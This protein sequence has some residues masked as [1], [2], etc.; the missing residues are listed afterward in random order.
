MKRQKTRQLASVWEEPGATRLDSQ[1]GS[2]DS[3]APAR[4]E[5]LATELMERVVAGAN[6]R[7]ALKRVRENKG[8]P[9][10]DGMTVAQLPEY[11]EREGPRLKQELLEQYN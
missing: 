4:P 8:S 11:L 5:A 7:Q 10:V 1:Q 9:G 6:M 3:A 2:D